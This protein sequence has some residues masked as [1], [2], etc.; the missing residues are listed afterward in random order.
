MKLIHDKSY[1]HALYDAGQF[2]E[3]WEDEGAKKRLLVVEGR[4][5]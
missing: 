3:H 4:L 5:P 1:R 2:V